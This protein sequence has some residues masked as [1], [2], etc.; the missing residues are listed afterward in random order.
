MRTLSLFLILLA[1]I[2]FATWSQTPDYVYATLEANCTRIID[3]DTIELRGGETV[4][5][6]GIN[7]PELGEPYADEAKW[8]LHA[9]VAHKPLR[10]ELDEEER[11]IYN[12]L[13]AHIYVETE[14]GWVL[15]NAELVRAGLAKL[16]FIPPNARYYSYFETALEEALL[17]RRGMW[18]TIG[19]CLTI[20]ELE[21]DLNA[22][23]TEMVTV[24]FTIGEVT[25]S[26][27]SI[28]LY[29]AEGE[30]GFYVKIPVDLLPGI[31]VDSFEDLIGTCIIVTGIVDCERVGLG[32]SITLEYTDQL[33]LPCPEPVETD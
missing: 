2:G 3:G 10:L 12:R 11:D 30:Y 13:L 24:E 6:L 22:C 23:I 20:L 5:L 25:E 28:K 27:R 14:D 1:V 31:G 7:T 18:G 16:L 21:E 9:W 26:A 19:G 4:R 33:L 32:P 15:V 8:A 29:S 17:Q